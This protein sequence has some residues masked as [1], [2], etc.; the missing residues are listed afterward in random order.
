MLQPIKFKSFVIVGINNILKI[1]QS[2][3]D[4]TAYHTVIQLYSFIMNALVLALEHSAR[5][6]ENILAL[7]IHINKINVNLR[8]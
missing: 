3:L 6:F 5:L 1:P 2:V 4:K 7:N 8:K